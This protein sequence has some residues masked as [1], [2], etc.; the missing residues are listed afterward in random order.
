MIEFLV[1]KKESVGNVHIRLCTV[2]ESATV[3]RS[4]ASRWAKR[5]TS[6]ETG[7]AELHDLP[8]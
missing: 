8:P 1:A 6:S 2:Y 7:T 5:V 3:N 4:T